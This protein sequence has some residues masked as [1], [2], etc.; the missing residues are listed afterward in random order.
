MGVQSMN[1]KLKVMKK[2]IVILVSAIGL[3]A[4]AQDSSKHMNVL[5]VNGL[6]MRSQ[7]DANARVV[8]K[9]PFG[10][11]VEILERT[12]IDLQLGWIKDHWFKVSF[13]GREGYI[14]G[15]YLIELPAPTEVSETASLTELLSGYCASTLNQD[16][17]TIT[18]TEKSRSGDTLFYSLQKFDAGIEL[19][20]EKQND[21]R[22]SKLLLPISV[23]QTYV[24]LEALLKMSKHASLLDELRFVKGKDGQLTRISNDEGTIVVR[25][26][27]EELTELTI[28]AYQ[29]SN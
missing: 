28:T 14:F 21:R 24:L 8:T 26:L 3:N 13:R 25:S 4:F 22:T 29:L 2:L 10:K 1:Q 16:G 7:P 23:P 17:E 18:A 27:S 12:N 11:Q 15:G 20:L 5:A 19:E 9:V 6:N